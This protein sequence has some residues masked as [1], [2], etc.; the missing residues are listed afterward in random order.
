MLR[1]TLTA[2]IAVAGLAGLAI[3]A[4]AGAYVYWANSGSGTIGRA[5]NDGTGVNQSFINP[6]SSSNLDGLSVGTNDIFWADSFVGVGHAN[7]DGSSPN[8]SFISDGNRT[9][10]VASDS[11]YVFWGDT[12]RP[13]GIYRANIDGSSPGPFLPGVDAWGMTD[14][15]GTLYWADTGDTIDFSSTVAPSDNTLLTVPTPPGG[16]PPAVDY[17]AV[18]GGYV[19]WTDITNNTIGRASL[20]DPQG[21]ANDAFITGASDPEG[22]AVDSSHIY[23][24]NSGDFGDVVP[25]PNTIG[26]AN[27]DGTGVDQ[28]FI[29]GASTP[30]GLAA[31]TGGSLPTSTGQCKNGGWQQYGVFKNQG[32]CVSYVATHGK[33]RPSGS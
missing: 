19:Y 15:A 29:T 6:G 28:T 4:S 8:D 3:P 16:Q 5:S 1:R 33:N 11:T 10:G 23:W 18:G 31:D 32:D 9:I 22:I 21:T 24:S 7:I 12:F 14:V 17:V 2:A 26:R 27:L 13:R 30:E 25:N 20:A